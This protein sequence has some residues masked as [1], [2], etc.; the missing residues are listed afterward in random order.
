MR[1]RRRRILVDP[2]QVRLLL[3]TWA[4][5]LIIHSVS[6]VIVFA[7][8]VA[9]LRAVDPS[10]ERAIDAA[11]RFLALHRSLWPILGGLMLA[12]GFL[13]IVTTHRIFGPLLR[14]RTILADLA[15]GREVPP[16]RLRRRDALQ[17]EAAAINGVIERVRRLER[18]AAGGPAAHRS[19]ESQG[20][21]GR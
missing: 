4:A 13:S 5:I 17:R 11:S 14:I 20:V 1:R 6:A 21:A 9:E 19:E 18:E 2:L 12:T 16:L 7:P 8:L 15:E 10:D 3:G